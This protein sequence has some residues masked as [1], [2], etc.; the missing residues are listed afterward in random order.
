MSHHHHNHPECCHR[1][2]KWKFP[3]IHFSWATWRYLI[4]ICG[5]LTFTFIGAVM[6]NQLNEKPQ[7][8]EAPYPLHY[9]IGNDLGKSQV[10]V[11][12]QVNFDKDK[13]VFVYVF[14]VENQTDSEIM[15]RWDVLE[16]AMGESLPSMFT[17]KAGATFE[18][19]LESSLVPRISAGGVLVYRRVAPHQ[20]RMVPE[21]YDAPGPVPFSSQ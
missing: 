2:W 3:R 7:N 4:A 15:I 6:Y 5:L 13:N 11:S 17:V 18:H 10:R 8:S 12:H 1:K 16:K 14:R 20:Y 21:I 19:R 9:E